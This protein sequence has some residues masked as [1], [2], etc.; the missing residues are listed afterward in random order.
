[1]SSY[2]KSEDATVVG[3]IKGMEDRR[4]AW[5]TQL[6]KL[7][8]ALGGKVTAMRSIS[9]THAGGFKPHEGELSDVHW[10]KK[11]DFGN[12]GL[13]ATGKPLKGSTKEE[14]A[15]IKVEHARLTELWAANNP[16]RFTSDEAWDEVGINASAVWMSGGIMFQ[17]NGVAFFQLGF[18]ISEE[19]HLAL[20]AE[21]KGTH[22]WIPGAVEILG[23]EWEEARQVKNAE[24]AA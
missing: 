18:S 1:M 19:K 9:S 23:S 13:R 3:A 17:L 2:Y 24:K 16:G 8:A 12:R 7:G 11:D 14:R 20:K 5:F 10:C 4:T 15:A 22:G 21:G 6:T